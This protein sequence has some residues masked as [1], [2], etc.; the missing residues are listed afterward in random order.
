M[1]KHPLW[2]V[3]WDR[4]GPIAKL[5]TRRKQHLIDCLRG[6]RTRHSHHREDAVVMSRWLIL[7][8]RMS[9]SI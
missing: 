1:Y 3:N 9:R 8:I 5:V 2:L 7:M 4:S 6:L